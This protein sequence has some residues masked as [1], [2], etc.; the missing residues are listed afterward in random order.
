M[1]TATQRCGESLPLVVCVDDF[2]LSE[3]I[4]SAV[5]ELAAGGA[6]SATSCLVNAP[7]CTGGALRSAVAT[8][9][10]VGLHLNFT[11]GQ[12]LSAGLRRRW[13]QFPPLAVFLAR[14]HARLLPVAELAEECAAQFDRFRELA[15]LEP[16]FLDG[17]QHVHHLP[18]VRAA[19]L[20]IL[21]A[22]AP[23][24]YV[25]STE[26]PLGPGS[27]F[28]R[29]VLRRSGGVALGQSLRRAGIPA[30]SPLIGTYGFE[31]PDY[32]SL[33]QGWL[34]ATRERGSVG[35][36]Y[37]H[38]GTASGAGGCPDP[39]AAA[40][41]REWRYLSSAAWLAD[42]AEHGFRI[43]RGSETFPTGAQAGHARAGDMN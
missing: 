37:C 17:H 11:E 19:W 20:P 42:L 13:E 2:G 27:A 25:R 22:R 29:W 5:L 26:D 41:H 16:C 1:T 43:A 30:A 10:D 36:L 12:P 9:I 6:I 32:R 35:L 39:I 8:G 15:G 33:V 21:Q 38:P 31:D 40:R 4:N 34:R 28:K 18:G 24:A 14:A 23:A 7:A 3:A